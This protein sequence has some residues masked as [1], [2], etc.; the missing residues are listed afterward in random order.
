MTNII[1]SGCCGK[2]GR[3]I[4][5][6]VSGRD[7]CKIVAGV[8][9]NPATDLGYPVYTNFGDIKED[10]DV[11]IDFSHPNVLDSL[12][13]F[14]IEK[15]MPVVLATTGFSALQTENIKAAAKEIPLFFTF[16][17]S[18]G[19]NLLVAL[20]KKAASV[21]EGNFDIEI[22]EKHH[23]QKIDAPSGTAIML[24]EAI[25]KTLDNKMMYE[26]DR[27]SKREKRPQNEIGIHSIRGGNI[28]GEH[29]VV[30]AGHDEVITLSHRA[31]SK[32]VFAVGAVK[33]ALYMKGKSKGLYDMN[34]VITL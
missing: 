13:G 21:L 31:T 5:A 4:T 19:I 10:A 9:I 18:L 1:L 12:L 3:V 17:M 14:A 20:S 29:E 23:N 34:N 28:V 6:N 15:S 26:Y 8:D 33:A 25:N 32:E 27:H 7:D 2:M 30:F 16:N 22:I 24:A 11:I